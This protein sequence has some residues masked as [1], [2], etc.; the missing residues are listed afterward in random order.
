MS[1]RNEIH[2]LIDRLLDALDDVRDAVQ[3][4][5]DFTEGDEVNIINVNKETGEIEE[6]EG[7]ITD[8]Y[9]TDED[10]E[11]FSRAITDD[12]R[13]F[14]GPVNNGGTRKGTKFSII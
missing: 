13:K 12:G 4:E 7:T 8:A 6:L 10:G 3:V 5:S 14:R 9:L 11:P 2:T 1:L